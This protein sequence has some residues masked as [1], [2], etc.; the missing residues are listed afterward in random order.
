[1]K[2]LRELLVNNY[3]SREKI[4]SGLIESGYVVE[5][6]K[7]TKRPYVLNEHNFY[8]IIY[9]NPKKKEKE[10]WVKQK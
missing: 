5:V 8:V 7:R 1:M 4:C 10:E 2:K 9:E 6:E 3:A